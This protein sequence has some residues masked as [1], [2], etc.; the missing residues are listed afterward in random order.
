MTFTAKESK[1]GLVVDG[2]EVIVDGGG[3]DEV[4]VKYPH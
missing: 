1:D 4:K 3:D 2:V